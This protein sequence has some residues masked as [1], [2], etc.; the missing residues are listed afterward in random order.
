MDR[1]TDILFFLPD[2][3]RGRM[4]RIKEKCT[5]KWNSKKGRENLYKPVDVKG[6]R[7]EVPI[8]RKIWLRASESETKNTLAVAE[9]TAWTDVPV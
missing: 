2:K 7:N 5:R 9:A 8:P 6:N 4:N 3:T 1:R